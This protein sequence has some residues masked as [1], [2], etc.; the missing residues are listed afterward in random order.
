VLAELTEVLRRDKFAAV[1]PEPDRLVQLVASS[2]ALVIPDI[3]LTLLADDAD[4]RLLEAAAMADADF[5]V[6]GDKA[7]LDFGR[8]ERTRIGSSTTPPR[9]PGAGRA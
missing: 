5:I 8:F 4:N 1:F 7:V 9:P 3:K 6:T 2:T